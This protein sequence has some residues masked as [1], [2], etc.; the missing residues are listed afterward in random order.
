[1]ALHFVLSVRRDNVL[2]DAINQVWRRQR[3]EL[4][5]PLKV[6]MGLD[7]GEQGIDHGG[8]QQ[9]FFRVLFAEALDPAYGM[10]GVD[11]RT[12]MTWFR[13][14]SLEPLY[15]FEVLG[16]LMSIAVYNFITLPITFP[17]AFY[18]KLL[19]LKVKT[20]GHIADGWPELARGLQQMLDWSDGDVGD[21]F[22]RTYQFSYEAFGQT[23]DIDM[24]RVGRDEPWPPPSR[25]KGKEREKTT[26]FELP[27]SPELT[28]LENVSPASS[29]EVRRTLSPTV[30][31]R[32]KGSLTPSSVQSTPDLG[33][34]IETDAPAASSSSSSSAVVTNATR[35]RYVSDYVHWLTSKSIAPQLE[36]FVK[37]F[38]TCL[39]RT[40]LSMF[41][42]E[43]LQAVMEG[44]QEIDVEA[45][46]RTTQYEDGYGPA[47]PQ[48]R[49]FWDVVR[50]FSPRQH[51]QLLEFV[52]ASDRV[53][54]TGMGSVVFIVQRNGGGDDARLPTSMTCF[55]RLLLPEY[56]A[57][58]VLAGRLALAV[59]N[60][61]GFGVA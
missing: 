38:A 44:S 26:S 3:M 15:K 23:V 45:L 40:A 42:P 56:S 27:P 60:S 29:P 31:A 7:E 39:D 30:A 11:E 25:R 58:A 1:M 13:P 37:G 52:T 5:R 33:R 49:W 17:L 28:P 51:R 22:L 4:M 34:A 36:A 48:I 2:T 32:A 59:D 9:E 54:V 19:G 61:R 55:G 20:I 14:G 16:M 21:V 18:R 24:E 57:R 6:L 8:V 41:T 46:Q 10:F 35:S 43:A 12:R 47:H 50:D 53:P